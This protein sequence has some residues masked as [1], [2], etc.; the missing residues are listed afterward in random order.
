[1]RERNEKIALFEPIFLKRVDALRVVRCNKEMVVLVDK[2]DRDRCSLSGFANAEHLLTNARDGFAHVELAGPTVRPENF[3][4]DYYFQATVFQIFELHFV[5]PNRW[6]RP[7][8][9]LGMTA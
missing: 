8:P 6:S 1:M 9:R 5:P 7:I 3:C 4:A 2:G